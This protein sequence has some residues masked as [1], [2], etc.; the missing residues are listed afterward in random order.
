MQPSGNKLVSDSDSGVNESTTRGKDGKEDMIENG[1]QIVEEQHTSDPQPQQSSDL[2]ANPDGIVPELAENLVD[3]ISDKSEESMEVAS[4]STLSESEEEEEDKMADLVDTPY[5]SSHDNPCNLLNNSLLNRIIFTDL[6][7]N[8]NIKRTK[9]NRQQFQWLGNLAEIKDFFSLALE[10]E[11]SWSQRQLKSSGKGKKPK[12]VHTFCALTGDMKAIWHANGT[13]QF[14]GTEADS[15]KKEVI[16]L[17]EGK[18]SR[19]I[20][21]NDI[22]LKVISIQEEVSKLWEV[23]V[24]LRTELRRTLSS[25]SPDNGFNM[26]NTVDLTVNSDMDKNQKKITDFFPSITREQNR[27]SI[28]NRLER[29]KIKELERR[30]KEAENIK[31]RLME[32]NRQLRSEK[33]QK[34]KNASYD[35]KEKATKTTQNNRVLSEQVTHRKSK[36]KPKPVARPIQGQNPEPQVSYQKGSSAPSKSV[37]GQNTEH[38]E[39]QVSN[40]KGFSAP[41]KSILL[42]CEQKDKIKSNANVNEAHGRNVNEQ[43]RLN[44]NTKANANSKRKIF[45]AG[46]SMIKDVK[47]WLLSR[48]KYV[49]VYSFS[50]ADTHDMFDFIKP[51]LS[52][53]P[54]EIILH[55]GTNNLQSTLSPE[56]IVDEILKLRMII[57][58]FGIHCTISTLVKR[59]DGYWDKGEEVNRLLFDEIPPEQLIDNSGL[60]SRH[61]NGS[62][63]HLN[64]AGSARLASNF[65]TH[66][67][68]QSL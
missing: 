4:S 47:G 12:Y 6:A 60:E 35:K 3:S 67:R 32:E 55:I 5:Q 1:Y 39:P 27:N 38:Q 40:Q 63:L 62:R 54:D 2:F 14:Q 61:L 42:D 59:D 26:T 22:P 7:K 46:D 36:V 17:L 41:S 31:L 65:R 50:G 30:L 15:V 13:L 48:Q 53:N 51:L 21:E 29:E 23:M 25:T 9:T 64:T 66:I 18:I 19:D 11:G 44:D 68:Q 49:K 20:K 43:S 34:I 56:Q 16:Q 33:D 37:Q 24:N 28:S 10:I 45:I 58:S 52:K 8:I 57:V